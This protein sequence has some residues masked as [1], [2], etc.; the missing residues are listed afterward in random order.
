MKTLSCGLGETGFCD[1]CSDPRKVD[2]TP[3]DLFLDCG[4]SVSKGAKKIV[5]GVPDLSGQMT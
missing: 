5:C 4:A 2:M 1:K 3:S